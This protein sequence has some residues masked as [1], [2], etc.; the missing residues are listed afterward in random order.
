MSELDDIFAQVPRRTAAKF[1][2][3]GPGNLEELAKARAVQKEDAE[4]RIFAAQKAKALMDQKT[5]EFKISHGLVVLFFLWIA[6]TQVAGVFLFTRGFLLSRLVLESKSECAV[7]PLSEAT[8]KAEPGDGC[9]HPK[10]F[11]KAV[12]I[13]IDALRYDFTVP[14]VDANG[15]PSTEH[16]HNNFKT[17][18][19]IA[20]KNPENAFLLPFIADPPT[21]TLQRLKGLTTGTLP[22]FMDAGSNFDGTA[23]DEDNFIAQLNST[24]KKIAFMGDDTWTALFPGYFDIEHPYESLNVWDLHTVDEGVLTHMFPLLHPSNTSSW[25]VMIGHFLGVDHAGHRYGPDHPAMAAKQKQ[26]DNFVQ[27]LVKAVDDDTLVVIMGDHGMD[28]KG[29]HGGESQLELEAALWMY[30]RKGL[31]GRIPGFE[32]PPKSAEERSVAQIDLVPTLALLLGLPIP[33]NNLGG[34]IPEAFIGRNSDKWDNLANAAR[35]ASSQIERYQKGYAVARNDDLNV[36][37]RTT[38]LWREAEAKFQADSARTTQE[39]WRSIH[40][41]FLHHQKETLGVC[42]D[43][44]ARFDLVSMLL[45]I[46]VLVGSVISISVFARGITGNMK[47]ITGWLAGRCAAGTV[48]GGVAGYAFKFTELSDLSQLRLALFGSSAFG[49]VAFFVSMSFVHRRLQ[50]IL[51]TSIFGLMALLFTVLQGAMFAANSFTIWEDR[52]LTFFLGSFGAV[53]FCYSFRQEDPAMRTLGATQSVIFMILTWIAS[54]SRLCREEQMPYC[55]STYYASATSSVSS[56]F[57]LL[58]LYFVALAFPSIVK[59]Y[60]TGT[61]SY[62][63]PSQLYIGFALRI[64]LVCNALYWT[65]DSADNGEWINIPT[66]LL[67][68]AKHTIAQVVLALAFIGGNFAFGWAEPCLGIQTDDATTAED[69]PAAGP[70]K[71]SSGASTSSHHSAP[72]ASSAPNPEL[73]PTR[74][75]ILGYANLHGSRF[76]LLPLT[77]YIGLALLQKPL[78]GASMAALLWQILALLEIIDSNGLSDS[79]IGPVI[80]AMLGSS[81]YFSTGHQA[82]LSSIQWETAFI[83][84]DTIRQPWSALLMVG[85]QWG[86]QILATV[87]VP[88]LALWKQPAKEPGLLGKVVRVCATYVAYHATI[89][90]CTVLWAG[91]LRRHLML[92]RVFSPRFMLGALVLLIADVLTVLVGVMGVRWNFLSIGEIFGFA[93]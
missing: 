20:V 32:A 14:Q 63:G 54:F 18:H 9:W 50:N 40:G 72:P 43:M 93:A 87:A 70:E 84:T 86:P 52:I 44:W 34:P 8:Y 21:T 7:S 26:M 58:L 92:Y 37:T 5:R 76:F 74:I 6:Y 53:A 56:P 68:L 75:T 47:E 88:T 71:Q 3:H 65:L 19:E 69:K 66:S 79:P 89:A 33:F 29:D 36:E 13:L 85:N 12:I 77:W 42:K 61:K 57:S 28:P 23:I 30:S 2:K 31:F 35:L 27:D 67:K 90:T 17:L 64:G 24:G 39:Y 60:Y 15:M 22:T 11:D 41:A 38:K 25:D 49:L 4:E 78:G 91:H 80:L 62:E 55:E 10:T 45:G 59:S 48:L 83:P 73:T 16:Y 81:H 46:I 82:T 1:S 51:P